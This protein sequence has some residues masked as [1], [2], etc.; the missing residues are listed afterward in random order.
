MHFL[1]LPIN[2]AGLTAI[3][4]MNLLFDYERFQ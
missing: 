3:K 4:L 1:T 2:A